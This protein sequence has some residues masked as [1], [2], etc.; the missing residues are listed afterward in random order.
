MLLHV[1]LLLGGKSGQI[2]SLISLVFAGLQF[3]LSRENF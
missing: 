3:G 1:S 2:C